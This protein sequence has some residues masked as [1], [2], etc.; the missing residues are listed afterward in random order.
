MVANTIELNNGIS[1]LNFKTNENNWCEV[2]LQED[3]KIYQLG[4]EDK[5]NIIEKLKDGLSKNNPEIIG[6]LDG[7]PV[8]WVWSLAEKHSSIYI[9]IAG[10]DRHLF[11]QSED[12]NTIAKLTLS[13]EVCKNWLRILGESS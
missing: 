7:I 9:G 11:I 5:S 12:G 2:E 13:S 1:A 10:E 8:A 6:E 3:G 4:A